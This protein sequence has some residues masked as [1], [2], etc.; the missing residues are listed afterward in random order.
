MTENFSDTI[1]TA[2]QRN[3][4]RV[5]PLDYPSITCEKCG[6]EYFKQVAIFKKIPGIVAGTGSEP[7]IYPIPVYICEKCGELMSEYKKDF[8]KSQQQNNNQTSKNNIIL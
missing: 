6:N 5:N 7:I 1:N 4:V 3:N 8:E 2:N